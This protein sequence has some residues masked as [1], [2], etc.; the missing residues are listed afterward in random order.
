MTNTQ[1]TTKTNLTNHQGPDGLPSFSPSGRK[2]AFVSIRDGNSDIYQ[3]DPD[4]SK[5]QRLTT[6]AAFENDP[7]FSPDGKKIT[8]QSDR[9]GNTEI[10]SMSKDGSKDKNLSDNL[11]TDVQPDWGVQ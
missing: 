7:A 9:D 1:T 8:F 3:M 4:G 5:Q 11:D 10:Y 2:I 6:N